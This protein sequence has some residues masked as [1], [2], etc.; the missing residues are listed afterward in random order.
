MNPFRQVRT[1][2]LVVAIA[3]ALSGAVAVAW[4]YADSAPSN[5][6]LVYAVR[7]DVEA[8]EQQ[9][10]FEDGAISLAEYEAAVRAHVACLEAKGF[11]VDE[12][13]MLDERQRYSYQ[14]S[15]GGDANEGERVRQMSQECYLRHLSEIDKVW[16]AA[17]APERA[18]LEAAQFALS[19]CLR[20]NGIDAPENPGP[21]SLARFMGVDA[22]PEAIECSRTVSTEFALPG[23][24]GY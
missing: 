11:T 6:D 1:F 20:D 19:S 18:S 14:V 23:F 24:A 2:A 22:K 8:P 16:S 17:N 9:S 3:V 13:P 5:K 21:G 10:A 12:A 4:G 7:P 15:F